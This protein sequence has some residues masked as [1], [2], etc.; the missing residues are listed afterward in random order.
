MEVLPGERKGDG[1]YFHGRPLH[2]RACE[3]DEFIAYTARMHFIRSETHMGTHLE[4]PYKYFEEGKDVASLRS[5][6][7]WAT[8]CM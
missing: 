8:P 6:R 5:S 1:R 2:G 3:V 7:S 4:S